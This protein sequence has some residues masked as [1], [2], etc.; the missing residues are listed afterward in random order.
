MDA[1][2]LVQLTAHQ[3][4]TEAFDATRGEERNSKKLHLDRDRVVVRA[5]GHYWGR[6][7]P[8]A[9]DLVSDL[10]P[11]V[12]RKKLAE[13]S[14][15]AAHQS[16]VWTDLNPVGGRQIHASKRQIQGHHCH[17]VDVFLVDR[18]GEWTGLGAVVADWHRRGVADLHLADQGAHCQ[19]GP[20]G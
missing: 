1:L 8:V 9:H 16:L 17:R 10:C 4:L 20:G 15:N 14:S 13:I 5:V 3:C 7:A 18:L 2:L 11:G 12:I 19:N 6:V